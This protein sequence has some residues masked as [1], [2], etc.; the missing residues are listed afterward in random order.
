MKA[1]IQRVSKA[2][3]RVDGKVTGKISK[4]LLVL[5]GVHLSDSE[6]DVDWMVKKIANLRI[7]QDENDKMNLSTL[8]VKGEI[9][10]V[11]QFTLYGDAQ[12][13]N[14]PSFIESAK[15]DISEPLYES[16]CFKM[17]ETIGK[18]VQK[19]IFGAMMEVDFINDGPVTIILESKKQ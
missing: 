2:E 15:P 10:V 18:Q 4:G 3:V 19:G 11:S 12:K 14:R 5:L 9:L 1:V 7:F 17:S 16:F 6:Q 13:G 8:N